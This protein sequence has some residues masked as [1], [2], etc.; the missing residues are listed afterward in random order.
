MWTCSKRPQEQTKIRRPVEYD[1]KSV[2]YLHGVFSSHATWS[3][4]VMAAYGSK[5]SIGSWWVHCHTNWYYQLIQS[6]LFIPHLE[7]TW[8]FKGSL[9]HPN[10]VTSRNP[11]SWYCISRLDRSLDILYVFLRMF[12]LGWSMVDQTQRLESFQ[13]SSKL[14]YFLWV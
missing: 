4:H 10:K 3:S 11:G 12:A 2:M 14:V 8:P 7:V 9:N 13:K 6:D 1:W 5:N